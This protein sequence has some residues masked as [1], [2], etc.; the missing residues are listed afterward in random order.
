SPPTAAYTVSMGA[1]P[2][3]DVTA[4]RPRPLLVLGGH[5]GGATP[6]QRVLNSYDDVAVF[7]EHEG[8]L[9]PIAEA[10]F[11]GAESTQMF[12][13]VHA[14]RGSAPRSDWQAWMSAVDRA[15]WDAS[16]RALVTSLFLP[17]RAEGL[18]H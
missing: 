10:Y 5:R 1:A 18:R 7:G 14:P 3:G 15:S 8:A 4:D 12:A 2:H 16:F 6:L 13:D 17:A 11:R 9:T